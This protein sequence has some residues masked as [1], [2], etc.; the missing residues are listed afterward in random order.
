MMSVS[1]GENKKVSTQKFDDS[2][3]V[4]FQSCDIAHRPHS[5]DYNN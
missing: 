1:C 2:T 4:R 5:L 3:R